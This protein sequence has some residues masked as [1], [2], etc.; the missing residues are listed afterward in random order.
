MDSGAPEAPKRYIALGD[1]ISIDEYP[2]RETGR[3]G[4]GAVSLFRRD[5]ES[6]Y[7]AVAV[8]NHTAD[9]ATTDDVLRSQLP[10]VRESDQ[11]A[12]VTVTAGGNDMLLNLG[13]PR[14]PAQLVEGIVERI[15]RIIAT[16][17]RKLPRSTIF[18]GTVYDPSDGANTLYGE[19]LDR[20]A[21]WL[22][23]VNEAIRGM[24]GPGVV[25]IDIHR[26]F[27]GHGLSVPEKQRWYWD[28]L[29]F[30][31]N[32]RG[33]AEVRRLWVEALDRK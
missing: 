23:R 4:L 9:G 1:S 7:G 12:L 10:R 2:L 3:H 29:I 32:A 21:Q 8:E 18:L 14:P 15:E 31:P 17:R 5:L 25:I 20:E 19:R 26:A 30:E 24:A 28:G 22:A 13:N 6:R 33:A 27:L 11:S 16:V